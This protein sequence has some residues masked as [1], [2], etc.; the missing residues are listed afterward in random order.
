MRQ[1][2]LLQD[3]RTP[4]K[5]SKKGCI[6]QLN[7]EETGYLMPTGDGQPHLLL[8]IGTVESNPEWFEEKKY[9]SFEKI[10]QEQYRESNKRKYN[11]EKAY[12]DAKYFSQE[13]NALLID[14]IEKIRNGI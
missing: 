8:E 6:V 7:K 14:A 3:Y 5:T 1:Y 9:S 12:L 11:L 2:I 10:L 13:Q 4:S